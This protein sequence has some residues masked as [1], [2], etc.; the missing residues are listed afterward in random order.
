[1]WVTTSNTID[2]LVGHGRRPLSGRVWARHLWSVRERTVIERHLEQW[3]APFS[4]LPPL[5]A[6]RSSLKRV[7]GEISL[8]P[9]ETRRQMV[10]RSARAVAHAF[11]RQSDHDRM[12]ESTARDGHE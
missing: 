10:A 8:P 12:L 2:S 11:K 6:L 7:A 3:L 5:P 1:M 9:G 4:A